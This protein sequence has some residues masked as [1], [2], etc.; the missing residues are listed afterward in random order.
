MEAAHP[1]ARAARRIATRCRA[2]MRNAAAVIVGLLMP[3]L[4][5][6]QARLSDQ[7]LKAAYVLNFIRYTDWPAHA[8]AGADDNI[9]VCTFG[10]DPGLPALGDIAGKQ[11]RGRTV[12]LRGIDSADEAR[13]CNVLFVREPEAR[14]FVGTLRALQRLPVLTVSEADAFVDVGG[15][16]G[17]VHINDRLQFEI[18]LGA[19]QQAQLKASLQLLRLARNVIEAR[20]R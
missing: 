7:Q 14:R 5:L 12:Q 11:I 20:P 15:M 8:F 4:A 10:G 17:L 3:T 6:A 9:V 1:S 2:F 19:L 16:I 13:A 18:N